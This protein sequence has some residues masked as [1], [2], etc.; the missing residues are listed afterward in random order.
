MSSTETIN[1]IATFQAQPGKEDEVRAQTLSQVE[2]TLAEPGCLA[3]LPYENPLRPGSWA[4]LE[5]WTDRAALDTH[6]ASPGLAEAL[7]ATN[8][9]LLALPEVKVITS[10]PS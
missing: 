6:F 9:F 10:L 8:D 5:E 7:S 4:V 1:V 2:P 3:Y